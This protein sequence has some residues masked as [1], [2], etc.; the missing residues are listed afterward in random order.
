M[1]VAEGVTIII[2]LHLEVV[3]LEVIFINSKDSRMPITKLKRQQ[4]L[5]KVLCTVGAV[6]LFQCLRNIL[7]F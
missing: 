6:W 3:L 7:F 1:L 4:L 5:S 2:H